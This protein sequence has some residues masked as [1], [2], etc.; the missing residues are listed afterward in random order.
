MICCC[1]SLYLLKKQI[2]HGRHFILCRSVEQLQFWVQCQDG[3]RRCTVHG[4]RIVDRACPTHTCTKFKHQCPPPEPAQKGPN[5]WQPTLV[6]PQAE[7]LA[8]AV[9]LLRQ[10]MPSRSRVRI[11]TTGLAVRRSLPGKQYQNILFAYLVVQIS[12]N[13]HH[14]RYCTINLT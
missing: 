5:L 9:P 2:S 8:P 4:R 7:I 10:R 11:N 14:I 1:E 6:H 12:I 3:P 13:Y